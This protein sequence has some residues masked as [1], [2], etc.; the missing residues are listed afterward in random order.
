MNPQIRKFPSD[1]FYKG[2]LKDHESLQKRD[3]LPLFEKSII[4]YDLINNLEEK[5]GK[6]KRNIGEAIFTKKLVIHLMSKCSE[7]KG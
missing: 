4:F 1:K 7:L 6:S 5:E 2:K 3:F